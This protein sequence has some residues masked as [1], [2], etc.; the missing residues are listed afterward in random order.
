M[1]QDCR[2]LD[3]RVVDHFTHL[4]ELLQ[5]VVILI[6][7]VLPSVDE[8]EGLQVETITSVSSP[9]ALILLLL[10]SLEV[11]ETHQKSLVIALSVK[12]LE[13]AME[14]LLLPYV[15]RIAQF[16]TREGV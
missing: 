6:L 1:R 4:L 8:G 3:V 5:V 7:Q 12:S 10:L 14:L 15:D 16:T 9:D 13:D 2:D 11:Y